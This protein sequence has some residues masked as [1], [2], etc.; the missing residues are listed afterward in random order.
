MNEE[1]RAKDSPFTEAEL[2]EA[3]DRYR[4]LAERT[5]NPFYAWAALYVLKSA[6]VNL[7][8]QWPAEKPLSL[9]GWI[10]SYLFRVVENINEL[11]LGLDTRI[12]R[13]PAP[14]LDQI[15]VQ[16]FEETM[17]ERAKEDLNAR[18]I[19]MSEA[20]SLVP[21][22]LELTRPGGWNAFASYAA[23]SQKANE[24]LSYEAMKAAGIPAKQALH[25]IGDATGITDPSRL[26][27]RIREGRNLEARE[28]EVVKPEG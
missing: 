18:Q 22:A 3:L 11:S 24:H 20:M 10:A 2:D 6:R 8:D 25:I 1:E 23:T 17:F 12:P 4:K 14:M 28:Q 19:S 16:D 7:G 26:Y 5:N 15:S 9:P 27:A 21:A 13:A